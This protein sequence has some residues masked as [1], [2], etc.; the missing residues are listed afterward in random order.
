MGVS[1]MKLVSVNSKINDKKLAIPIYDQH[2]RTLLNKGATFTE[3]S[4]NVIKKL[5]INSTYIEDENDDITVQNALDVSIKLKDL[6]LLKD[7]FKRAK[8]DKK[9]DERTISNIVEE[10][11]ENINTSENA[12]LFNDITGNEGNNNLCIHSLNV[13]IFAILIG[14][15]KKYDQKKLINLAEAALLHDVGKLF[16]EGKD[17]PKKGYNFIKNSNSFPV[18][19]YVSILQHHENADGSGYPEGI[20]EDKIYEFAKIINI[21]DTYI[22]LTNNASMGLINET[23]ENITAQ[24]A[25]KFGQSTYR[26]FMKSVYCYPNGLSVKLSNGLNATVVMQNKNFPL[27]PIVGTIEEDTPKLINLLENLTLFIK[28]VIL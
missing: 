27:R 20:G 1:I 21:C 13:C 14:I 28:E 7:V 2:G 26:D 12:F 5:G 23:I 6:M 15:N 11:I 9:I 17:H 8:A 18:T 25:E 24:A 22:N 19:V 10:I 16:S 3:N 4:I